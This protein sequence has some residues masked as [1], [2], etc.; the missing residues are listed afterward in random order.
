[1]IGNYLYVHIDIVV[2]FYPN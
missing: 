2:I 1:M